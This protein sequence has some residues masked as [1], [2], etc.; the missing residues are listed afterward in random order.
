MTRFLYKILLS[1]SPGHFSDI[2][3]TLTLK[4]QFITTQHADWLPQAY[5]FKFD[6]EWT[7]DYHINTLQITVR[8]ILLVQSDQIQE[9]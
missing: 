6:W 3:E 5:N 2:N 4:T 1:G 7:N 9:H 8:Q